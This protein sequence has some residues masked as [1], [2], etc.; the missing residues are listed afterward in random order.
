MDDKERIAA[1]AYVVYE[2]AMARAERHAKRLFIAL[3]VAVLAIVGTNIG[4]LIYISQY[5]F[6]S[7]ET[8]VEAKDGVAN[9]VGNDGDIINGADSCTDSK[10]NLEE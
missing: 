9:Y 10:A 4:W 7:T 2:G 6:T 5:D 8:I 1:V 3:V